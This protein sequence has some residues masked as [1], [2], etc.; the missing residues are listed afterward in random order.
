MGI[1]LR[2]RLYDLIAKIPLWT[3]IGKNGAG[4]AQMNN[5]IQYKVYAESVEFSE[6]DGI[7]YGKV[8]GSINYCRKNFI[9]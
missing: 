8:M 7:F 4:G 6:A 9:R 5:I 1:I 2:L 3:G